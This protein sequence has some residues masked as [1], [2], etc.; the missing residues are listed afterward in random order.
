MMV[1]VAISEGIPDGTPEL[2][3]D[4]G[5]DPVIGGDPGMAGGPGAAVAPG[6]CGIPEWEAGGGAGFAGGAELVRAQSAH[7]SENVCGES[8]PPVWVTAV[9]D[10]AVVVPF[11]TGSPEVLLGKLPLR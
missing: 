4:P 5:L 11:P 7:V 1:S 9:Q 3:V 10:V 6:A 8:T 2:V